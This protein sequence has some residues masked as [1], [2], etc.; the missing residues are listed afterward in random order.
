[1]YMRVSQ[2]QAKIAAPHGT[3]NIEVTKHIFKLERIIKEHKINNTAI[4]FH[5]FM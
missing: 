4:K 2:P 5:N 3:L 1:M